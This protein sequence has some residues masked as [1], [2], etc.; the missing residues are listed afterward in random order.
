MRNVATAS[1]GA[2]STRSEPA[3]RL[4]A[5][6]WRTMDEQGD[7]RAARRSSAAAHRMAELAGDDPA[8]AESALG[9]A[10]L[11]VQEQR[12]AAASATLTQTLRRAL[13]RTDP[14]ATAA[15][16][17]RARLAAELDYR[18][19][20][21]DSILTVLD[22][23]RLR[24]DAKAHADALHLAHHCL[25]GPDHG[26][27]R[28]PLAVE[29]VGISAGTGR[30]IDLLAGLLWL[31][32]DLLLAGE[33]HAVRH[34]AELRRLLAETDHLAVGFVVAA[35]DVLATI[36]AGRLDEAERM[37]TDCAERGH[38]A[39]DVDA[40]IWYAAHLL[41]IRWYQGRLPE[42]RALLETMVSS[43]DVSSVDNSPLA[44]LA[45]AAAQAGDHTRATSAL[46]AL[47]GR[48]LADLPRSSTWLPTMNGIIEAAYLI[49]DARTAARAYELL[50]P[51]RHLPM[52]A[53][54]GVTCF[55][56]VEHA[57]GVAALTVGDPD[58]AVHHLQAAVDH[59]LVLGHAPAT[60]LSRA[61]LAEALAPRTAAPERGRGHPARTSGPDGELRP[62]LDTTGPRA[63]T[64]HAPVAAA[65]FRIGRQWRVELG[66]RAVRVEHGVGM[67]H[68]SVLLANPG[69]EIP[70]ADLAAGVAALA[71]PG[72]PNGGRDGRADAV[73]ARPASCRHPVLDEAG[74]RRYRRRLAELRP[75]IDDLERRGE[76]ELA[77][78]SRTEQRW[79]VAELAG[80]VGLGGRVRSFPDE[81]ERARIAVGKAI[82]RAVARITEA[83]PQIG[84]HL[85]VNVHTGALCWYLPA[86]PGPASCSD[87]RPCR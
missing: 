47:R 44:A 30:R 63:G 12:T 51:Y 73:D 74:I 1:V 79:L 43:P 8:T 76:D 60:A 58:R 75:E 35:I 26:P 64:R 28:R 42:L 41:T 16:R 14:A 56:S 46:A 85:E 82:R 10:G 65:C 5:R 4:L 61:R 84:A 52:I 59:N 36:R 66:P 29:L 70:A 77:A 38:R 20:R 71:P 72:R 6:A 45:V 21:H 23:A 3:R 69:R 9:L 53:S 17:L 40:D 2:R 11:W 87:D 31:T 68:L 55:G 32:V 54:L 80:A 62:A 81:T 27:L 83:D 25:L 78:R 49:D 33:P 48:D 39:G 13:E 18:A 67:L 15:L 7:L 50:G 86:D 37:A 22:E 34:L 19:S 57:L 24:Q